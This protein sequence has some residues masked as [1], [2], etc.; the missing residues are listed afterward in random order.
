MRKRLDQHLTI[1]RRGVNRSRLLLLA[2][3][4]AQLLL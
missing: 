4:A 2:P 3:R 1:Y